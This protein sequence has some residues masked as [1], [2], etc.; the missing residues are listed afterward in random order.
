[1][2][3]WAAVWSLVSLAQFGFDKTRARS[4]GTR[5]PERRLLITALI[6]GWPGAKLGQRLFRHKT[7]KQPFARLLN[8]GAVLN[9]LVSAGVLA[10][11]LG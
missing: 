7:C 6:G 5:V 4:G 2:V 3:T 9:L 1:M 10:L 8:A 11:G